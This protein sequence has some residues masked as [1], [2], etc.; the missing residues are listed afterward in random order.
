M[1][2]DPCDP[3]MGRWACVPSPDGMTGQVL[4]C[5][6]GKKIW[7]PWVD[8]DKQCESECETAPVDA[9]AGIGV[10]ALCVCETLGR[11]SCGEAELGCTGP[12]ELTLCHGD[13]VVR[14]ACPNCRET[15]SG[16]YDCD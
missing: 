16:Y 6:F 4:R 14:A 12:D 11:E 9:C 8:Y 2:E 7:R 1:P 5:A 3:S 13:E 15:P 10:P